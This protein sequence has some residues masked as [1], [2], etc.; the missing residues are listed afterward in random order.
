MNLKSFIPSALSIVA[1]IGA[2]TTIASCGPKPTPKTTPNTDAVQISVPEGKPELGEVPTGK[3]VAVKL[4]ITA[5]D[6]KEGIKL[7][8]TQEGEAAFTLQGPKELPATGGE[9]TVAFKANKAGEYKAVLTAT[10]GAAS[11]TITFTANAKDGQTPPGNGKLLVVENAESETPKEITE[12][13]FGTITIASNYEGLE[14]KV[15]LGLIGR[16]IQNTPITVKLENDNAGVFSLPTTQFDGKAS[17]KIT[18]ATVSVVF[19]A[20][21]EGTFKAEIVATYGD[22]TKR[23]PVS[24]TLKKG[25]ADEIVAPS[26]PK[27]TKI[28]ATLLG[29]E[30]KNG[31]V[32]KITTPTLHKDDQFDIPIS[33]DFPEAGYNATVSMEK[34]ISR[35][36]WCMGGMCVINQTSITVN[37]AKNVKLDFHIEKNIVI[38]GFTNKLTFKFSK[39][40]DS[41]DLVLDFAIK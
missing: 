22:V 13:S 37:E 41:F 33:F 1:T 10:S 6:L 16:G 34:P 3:E 31:S 18:K 28:K 25:A 29:K 11:S 35:T 36:T 12:L 38:P 30:L 19:K 4:K 27:A 24:V 17:A 2:F 26:N 21:A 23:I 8:L 5:T 9:A 7:A 39:G 32:V 20:G 14:Y 40:D 15:P